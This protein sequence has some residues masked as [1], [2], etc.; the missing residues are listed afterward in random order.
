M[1]LPYRNDKL[2]YWDR[3]NPLFVVYKN[4]IG[5]ASTNNGTTNSNI[6]I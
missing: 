5:Y 3:N 4:N 1:Q 2:Q 6:G